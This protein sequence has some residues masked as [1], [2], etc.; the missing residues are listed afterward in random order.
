M[1]Q[2]QLVRQQG[3]VARAPSFIRLT[4]PLAERMLRLGMPMG[5][6][7]PLTVRGRKSGRPRTAVVAVVEVDRRRWV[8]SPYGE[9]HWIRNLRAAGEAL[10]E[11]DG[12]QV[13][14]R[15]VALSPEAGEAFYRDILAPYIGRLPLV[16]R[17]VTR[18]LLR[19]M[20][21]EVLADPANAARTR[22]VF[23]LFAR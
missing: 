12:R 11:R 4:S 20:A 22:P 6:N 21:P 18:T 17:V 15:A 23:E 7:R 5:P 1:V 9:V 19:R 10:I 14:V 13:A 3:S 16:W 8:A 2:Q